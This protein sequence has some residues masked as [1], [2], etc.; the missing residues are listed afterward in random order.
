MAKKI[1]KV[2]DKKKS[3]ID[4]DKIK[5]VIVDNKETIAK[6]VD[7]AGD[8]LDDDNKK[9]SKKTSKAT[10]KSSSKSSK[11]KTSKKSNASDLSTMIDL[12]GKFLK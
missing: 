5:D 3:K 2:E 11:K 12:A 10:K 4:L 8:F 6:I 7:I 9:S 1:V